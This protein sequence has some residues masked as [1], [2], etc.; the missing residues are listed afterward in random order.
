MKLKFWTYKGFSTVCFV[1]SLALFLLSMLEIFS[2]SRIDNI[3]QRTGRIVESRLETLEDFIETDGHMPEGQVQ[4]RKKLPEDMVIYRYVND[5]L[6][7]WSNQFS[8]IN[9]DISAKLEIQKLASQ[10]SRIVSPLNNVT[11]EFSFMN[12]GP[13]GI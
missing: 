10:R 5:S 2:Y 8:V 11:E 1:I 7:S 6:K 4:N 3:A 13:N 9:D 12:L